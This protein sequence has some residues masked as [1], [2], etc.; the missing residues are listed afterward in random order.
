MD[1]AQLAK[2]MAKGVIAEFSVPNPDAP[3][4][5]AI[6][7][8]AIMFE[9]PIGQLA[10]GVNDNGDHYK[11]TIKGYRNLIN[12][13]TWVNTFMGRHRDAVMHQV[14]GSYT[15]T[16][17]QCVIKMLQVAKTQ[18]RSAHADSVITTV[19]PRTTVRKRGQ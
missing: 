14:E 8:A 11:I 15:Q 16:T 18:L 4:L 12:D 19:T 7:I 13:V 5:E 3:Y 6:L 10:F 2:S 17:D 9:L 1:P